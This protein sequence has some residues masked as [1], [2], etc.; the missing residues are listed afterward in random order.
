MMK[1]R[2]WKLQAIFLLGIVSLAIALFIPV[3]SKFSLAF[4][5]II[6]NLS[7]LCIGV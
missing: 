6:I 1:W 4:K 2:K 3:F 7:F 5:P